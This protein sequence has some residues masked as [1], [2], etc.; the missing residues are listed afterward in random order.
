MFVV[1]HV[2]EVFERGLMKWRIYGGIESNLIHC[3]LSHVLARSLAENAEDIAIMKSK[4][5]WVYF[6]IQSILNV[7]QKNASTD[8]Q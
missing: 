5:L 2:E 7:A 6:T 8:R 1:S 4:E 3:S